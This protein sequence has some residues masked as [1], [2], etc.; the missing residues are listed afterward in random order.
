MAAI[1]TC[2]SCGSLNPPSEWPDEMSDKYDP[3]MCYK[4][5]RQQETVE[6]DDESETEQEPDDD[7]PPMSEEEEVSDE[8]N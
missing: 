7:L 2:L 1:P 8:L 4:C 6:Q 5:F 3:T